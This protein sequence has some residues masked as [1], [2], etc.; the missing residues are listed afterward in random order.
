MKG[1]VVDVY[2]LAVGGRLRV[3]AR[4]KAQNG[5]ICTAVMPERELSTILPRSIL[6][7]DEK[8]VSIQF[9][10]TINAIVKRMAVGRNVRLWNYRDRSY[11]AF[12]SWRGV[13]ITEDALETDTTET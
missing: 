7:G 10:P 12:L 3:E 9:L 2:S 4:V 13:T 6:I 5:E 1:M 11:F 8:K